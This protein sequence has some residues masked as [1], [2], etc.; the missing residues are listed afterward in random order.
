MLQHWGFSTCN[1]LCA[2]VL[3]S[4]LAGQVKSWRFQI[5]I[6]NSHAMGPLIIKS[7][8]CLWK[9]DSIKFAQLFTK[10]ASNIATYHLNMQFSIKAIC[11]FS[12]TKCD[13]YFSQAVFLNTY[14][15]TLSF[16]RKPHADLVLTTAASMTG[17]LE[18]PPTLLA[19]CMHACVH[20]LRI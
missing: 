20:V 19:I 13:S 16:L 7:N 5:N 1:C 14:L 10:M 6:V 8:S 12:N 15:D 3:F 2:L 11:Y 18:N 17:S 4:N 9:F